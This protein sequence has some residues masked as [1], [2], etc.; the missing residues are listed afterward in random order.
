[1]ARLECDGCGTVVERGT[2]QAF[3]DAYVEHVRE[4][5]PDWPFPEIAIRNVAEATQRLT[6]S[7][8][9]LDTIG[10]IE[11][12]PVTEERIEDWLAF[13]DHD[14]FAGNPVDAVCYC[15]GPLLGD[16]SSRPWQVNRSCMVEMLRNGRAY[17]YLAYAGGRPA[18]WVNAS[19]RENAVISVACFVIAPP[20]RR[21]GVAGALLARVLADAPARAAKVV[22]ASPLNQA[23][24]SDAANFRG[25]LGL[26]LAHG[27]EVVE[28]RESDSL[29]R[30]T[31][32]TV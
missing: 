19:M 10:P 16:T 28:R 24:A 18:G 13:F 3:S 2:L 14:A 17:G 1:M 12:H 23:D 6:G 26:F 5:H 8:E 31:V 21:H 9:R 15:T 29:V 32:R 27:F 25:H 4:V 11:V 20:F 30:W 7:T 22:E